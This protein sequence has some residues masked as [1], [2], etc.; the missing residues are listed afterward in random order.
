MRKTHLLL[1]LLFL[2]CPLAQAASPIC[3]VAGAIAD[4]NL[5]LDQ[6]GIKLGDDILNKLG[7]NTN[8]I[9][10]APR[11]KTP[12]GV[13]ADEL[14]PPKLEAQKQIYFAIG[15]LE[16][17]APGLIGDETAEAFTNVL[18]NKRVIDSNSVSYQTMGS[19]TGKFA[20][21]ADITGVDVDEV[22]KDMLENI[23]PIF[24]NQ[25]NIYEAVGY[26]EAKY[27]RDL[28]VIFGDDPSND[29]FSLGNFI[30]EQRSGTRG[31]LLEVRVAAARKSE[32]I[33]ALSADSDPSD[34]NFY[35]G[36]DC[37]T[38]QGAYNVAYSRE[39]IINK[40]RGD[41]IE[42][43]ADSI[44]KARDNGINYQFVIADN[45]FFN[46]TEVDLEKSIAALNTRIHLSRPDI[47][48]SIDDDIVIQK[49]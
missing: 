21:R 15:E 36:V 13:L 26:T 5:R 25:R 18:L 7:I 32:N 17:A 3:A 24:D 12:I 9:V 29:G 48:F 1:A 23:T 20:A 8:D 38:D 11:F 45:N 37:L 27:L 43:I 28:N 42:K 49:F 35:H 33:K 40:L 34:P 2:V 19:G 44:I 10:N 47:T 4:L 31:G 39:T 22:T 6:A 14:L 46:K 16:L 41:R 30:H